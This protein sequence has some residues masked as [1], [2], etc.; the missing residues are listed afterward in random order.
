MFTPWEGKSVWW[1]LDKVCC[2][3][4]QTGD[5]TIY[6]KRKRRKF[7]CTLTAQSYQSSVSLTPDEI[8]FLLITGPAPHFQKH[9][10]FFSISMFKVLS[11]SDTGISTS[12]FQWQQLKKKIAY[13][14]LN[15]SLTTALKLS[16]LVTFFSD[17]WQVQW[18]H[19]AKQQIWM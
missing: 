17:R 7:S 6:K 3:E 16:T 1:T 13:F 15:S 14:N 2:W 4:K 8:Y 12:K 18:L 19:R 11:Y 5:G 9:S 10:I